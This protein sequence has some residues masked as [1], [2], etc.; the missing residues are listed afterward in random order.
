MTLLDWFFVTWLLGAA[1]GQLGGWVL[2]WSWEKGK[3]EEES[4]DPA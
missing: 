2:G 3:K 1:L 4:N